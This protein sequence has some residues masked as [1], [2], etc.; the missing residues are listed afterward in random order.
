[1][2]MRELTDRLTETETFGGDENGGAD[3]VVQVGAGQDFAQP[4]V[5]EEDSGRRRSLVTIM[6]DG[7]IHSEAEATR[8][9]NAIGEYLEMHGR[10]GM[11]RIVRRYL[12]CER[13]L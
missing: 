10:T 1:M 4:V 13:V 11:G 6:A 2:T 9:R 8:V 12:S 7:A 5:A 3:C